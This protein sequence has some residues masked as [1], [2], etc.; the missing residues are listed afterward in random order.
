MH[1]K[2]S[3]QFR[4]GE[5][6]ISGYLSLFLGVISLFAVVCFLFPV[7]MLKEQYEAPHHR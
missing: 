1:A 4:L 5:G 3:K 7:S 2:T 6:R